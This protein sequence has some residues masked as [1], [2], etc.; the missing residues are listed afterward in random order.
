MSDSV[1]VTAV[2]WH[3]RYL[4]RYNRLPIGGPDGFTCRGGFHEAVW[5]IG[6]FP[7]LL[8]NGSIEET[9]ATPPCTDRRWPV[10]CDGCSYL[11]T[12]LDHYQLLHIA[13]RDISE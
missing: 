9:A 11:F 1:A 7:G 12:P 6:D 8:E 10:Y 3:R 2:E 5:E 13:L 4:R